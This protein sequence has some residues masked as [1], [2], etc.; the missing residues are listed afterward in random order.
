MSQRWVDR[1]V[2]TVE[3][4][5]TPNKDARRK[6]VT[7]RE[8]VP[9]DRTN[10]EFYKN[11]KIVLSYKRSGLQLPEEIIFIK[12]GNRFWNKRI[13]DIGCGGGRTTSVL[14]NVSAKYIGVDYSQD[15]VDLCRDRFPD[16]PFQQCDARNIEQF[17]D[18]SFDL[19]VFSLNG[20]DCMSH[21]DRLRTLGEMRRVLCP[22]ELLI[23]SS[24]N[25]H[26]RH[27]KRMPAL[28]GSRNPVTLMRSVLKYGNSWKNHLR[29]RR[30]QSSQSEYAII[31]DSGHEYRCLHYYISKEDQ[32]AQLKAVKFNVLDM[33]DAQGDTTDL[34]DND[35]ASPWIYYVA[36][37][38]A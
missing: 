22:N 28:T 27:A 13:L 9:F 5:V 33:F 15:M 29:N 38:V 17:D 23:F 10:K 25:R 34:G 1:K 3:R 12:Y 4:D 31:N 35:E 19:V 8:R 6:P 24:H 2:V 36:E 26:Y 11:A 14:K 30:W 32:V 37:K 16:V 21:E 20:L 7:G 18:E